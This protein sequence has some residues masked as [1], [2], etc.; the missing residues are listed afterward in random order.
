M[1]AGEQ[2]RDGLFRR[3]SG[4]SL[5]GGQ[6]ASFTGGARLL[7]PT[8]REGFE[9]TRFDGHIGVA[10]ALLVEQYPARALG[11]GLCGGQLTL[12]IG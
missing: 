10:G 8:Q 7:A 1:I 12:A 2:M 4:R 11:E 9:A 6:L 3:M 5:G